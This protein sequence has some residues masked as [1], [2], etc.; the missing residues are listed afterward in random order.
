MRNIMRDSLVAVWLSFLALSSAA[1]AFESAPYFPLNGGDLWNYKAWIKTGPR[2]SL[3][4]IGLPPNSRKDGTKTITLK[5]GPLFKDIRSVQVD[6]KFSWDPVR[7]LFDLT[8]NREGITLYAINR[9]PNGGITCEPFTQP[10]HYLPPHVELGQT[11][12]ANAEFYC[13]AGGQR[14]QFRWDIKIKLVGFEPVTV[15]LGKF[16]ALK[17]ERSVEYNYTLDPSMKQTDIDTIWLVE[18]IGVVKAKGR[19]VNS[20]SLGLISE[21]EEELLSTTLYQT[22]PPALN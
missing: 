12:Q 14:L 7:E 6:S 21:H 15:P 16:N 17:I 3:P 11:Y 22:R 19:V 18:H 2:I 8:N 10:L 13:G 5:S 4:F 20:S 1:C 9:Q